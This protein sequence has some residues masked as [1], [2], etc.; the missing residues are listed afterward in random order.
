MNIPPTSPITPN[1]IV[2]AIQK[3][4]ESIERGDE[5]ASIIIDTDS[6][7]EPDE[8]DKAFMQYAFDRW[9]D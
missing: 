7:E 4:R 8:M 9:D 2:E 6:F 5:P 1:P 3:M